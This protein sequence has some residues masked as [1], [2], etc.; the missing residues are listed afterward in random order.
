MS[1]PPPI[2]SPRPPFIGD[3]ERPSG[4][5]NVATIREAV[6][7]ADLA[8]EKQKAEVTK[9][10]TT[11]DVKWFVATMASVVVG[12]VLVLAWGSAAMDKRIAPVS[13]QVAE[14]KKSAD[15]SIS[16]LRGDV[17][18]AVRAATRA[19]TIGEMLLKNRGIQPPPKPL[20]DGGQP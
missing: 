5:H 17:R 6:V 16:E 10:I 13:E 20:P 1:P 19:E 8:I 4:S 18:E 12:T 7:I 3:D 15:A 14:N 2:S 9:F 11:A